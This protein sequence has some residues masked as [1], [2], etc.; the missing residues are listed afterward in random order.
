MDL[1][2]ECDCSVRGGKVVS[3]I[4]S[5]TAETWQGLRQVC[6]VITSHGG[7]PRGH[8]LAHQCPPRRR[9]RPPSA[10]STAKSANQLH[11]LAAP[12]PPR[13]LC[14]LPGPSRCHRRGRP[15]LLTRAGT[16]RSLRYGPSGPLA[17]SPSAGFEADEPN[18]DCRVLASAASGKALRSGGCRC[19]VTTGTVSRRPPLTFSLSGRR[20][21][22]RGRRD[23]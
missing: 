8:R 22:F 13:R 23:A 7:T 18:L 11:H 20:G 16:T 3:P 15:P 4:L 14:A 9:H 12:R 5:N 21:K 10:G 2:H 17:I 19:L 1:T 6:G